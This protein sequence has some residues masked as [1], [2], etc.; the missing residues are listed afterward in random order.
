MSPAHSYNEFTMF[1][2][3]LRITTALITAFLI[4]PLTPRLLAEDSGSVPARLRSRVVNGKVVETGIN[5]YPQLGPIAGTPLAMR[6]QK[7]VEKGLQDGVPTDII[8][9]GP[10]AFSEDAR[11]PPPRFLGRLIHKVH[12]WTKW[13]LAGNTKDKWRLKGDAQHFDNR[14]LRSGDILPLLESSG[15]GGAL[16]QPGDIL[17]SGI[18]A[19][20]THL[21]L[22][23]GKDENGSPRIIHSMATPA[24]QQSYFQL[25]YNAIRS[26]W[27]KGR[28]GVFE[29]DLGEFFDRYERDTYFVVRDPKMTAEMRAK[30]I[31]R[32]QALVGRSYD[33]DMNQ[34]NDALY[35]TE[36]GSE[37]IR[38][39]YE[40]SG[41]DLP[42]LGTTAVHRLAL[43]DFPITPNNFLASPDLLITDCSETGW[44]HLEYVVGSHVTGCQAPQNAR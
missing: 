30:G 18:G 40:G 9:E 29:E 23:T 44:K 42:W 38:G 28:I 21:S 22:Y 8:I 4:C 1:A 33:Y 3:N 43:E 16:L 34:N 17:I 6:V 31:A 24:T 10:S 41:L 26:L 12:I 35:C 36:I 25:V 15:P 14:L 20:A 37:L 5:K 27:D 32:V 2:F 13:Q 19:I 11:R 39:A 7:S